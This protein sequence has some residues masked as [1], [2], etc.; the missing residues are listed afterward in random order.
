MSDLKLQMSLDGAS[1]LLLSL[2]WRGIAQSRTQKACVEGSFA[3]N[4]GRVPLLPAATPA[5]CAAQLTH[6]CCLQAGALNVEAPL[7]QLLHYCSA[8]LYADVAAAPSDPAADAAVGSGASAEAAPAPRSRLRQQHPKDSGSCEHAVREQPS[9]TAAGEL[10]QAG[11]AQPQLQLPP[12][13]QL[14]TDPQQEW[15][16]VWQPAVTSALE[17]R[18]CMT[19]AV[20]LP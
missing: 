7:I 16:S 20:N 1:A 4:G 13:G 14:G 19:C 9:M 8:A 2:V 15:R 12:A 5:C 3:A 17:V 10:D 6:A 18:L 11:G